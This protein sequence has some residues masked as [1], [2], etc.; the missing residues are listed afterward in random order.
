MPVGRDA[1]KGYLLEEA[2]AYLIRNAGYSLLVDPRQDPYELR[3]RGNGLVVKGRGGEH[4]VD[5]LGQLNWI[6]AFTFPIRLFVEAKFRNKSVGIADVRKAI[7]VTLDVN[8]K[9]PPIRDGK[10]FRQKHQYMYAL[11]S[12]SGFSR[13][14]TKMALAHSISLND[15]SWREFAPLLQSI[16]D[17]AQR[18]HDLWRQRGT[19]AFP[20]NELRGELRSVLDTSP[21]GFEDRTGLPEWIASE[22]GPVIDASRAYEEL[23]VGMTNGP[24]MLVLKADNFDRFIHE[25]Q[26]NPHHRVT[27]RWGTQ[28]DHGRT[29]IVTPAE[30]PQTY[31][32]TF[33][34]PR[35]LSKWVF[36]TS[37]EVRQRAW[38]IKQD[39]FSTIVIYR[40]VEGRDWLF[41]LE[42]DP[43]ETLRQ[44]G[45]M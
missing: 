6:P 40:Y 13:Y 41:R 24:Y 15:L 2:L 18:M 3:R 11:F 35:L 29:W 32:L 43:E 44:V 9:N 38:Q 10:P 19:G 39:F 36:A 25:A 26:I 21:P 16:H 5:V 8:Q 1:L 22:I 45:Q 30:G 14:A 7:G 42:F 33:R 23:L 28:Y 20:V 31:T 12:A 37:G 17:V 4:Q 27:I 34:L